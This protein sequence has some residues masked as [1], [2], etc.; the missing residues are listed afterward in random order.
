MGYYKLDQFP[1]YVAG[2]TQRQ[3]MKKLPRSHELSAII[4]SLFGTIR[5]A[6]VG[7]VAAFAAKSKPND[8]SAAGGVNDAQTV[9]N[10]FLSQVYLKRDGIEKA[11][12]AQV[13]D[14]QILYGFH[15]QRSML[16]QGSFVSLRDADVI[17]AF[18]A[19]AAKFRI[20]LVL[21]WIL[22]WAETPNKFAPGTEQALLDGGWEVS[23]DAANLALA[24]VPL[25]NGNADLTLSYIQLGADVHPTPFPVVGP[26]WLFASDQ[27]A[28]EN[29]EK[30]VRSGGEQFIEPVLYETGLP[31]TLDAAVTAISVQRDNLDVHVAAMPSSL[32]D[33][34]MRAQRPLDGMVGFD[35]ARS[36]TPLVWPPQRN[37]PDEL[38]L[39]VCLTRRNVF[40]QGSTATRN[41]RRQRV[42]TIDKNAAIVEAVMQLSG[43]DPTKRSWRE[44]PLRF[45]SGRKTHARVDEL[46]ASRYIR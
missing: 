23:Y 31:T 33:A 27:E 12:N 21:E 22:P 17:P 34:Y 4:V 39:P 18:N 3:V 1:A 11:Y 8:G 20:D 7:A 15:N 38:E 37:T 9:A 24:T 35:P 19:T 44:M 10:R 32:A 13:V 45:P 40:F 36:C 46:F 29:N 26:C 5:G 43:I 42:L 28:S 16:N 14:L 30:L 25:A 41:M 6:T 2:S